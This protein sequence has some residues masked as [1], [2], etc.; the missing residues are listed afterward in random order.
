M[1]RF[2]NES[3]AIAKTGIATNLNASATR[4]GLAT[5]LRN[6]Q[7][8]AVASITVVGPAVELQARKARLSKSL[9]KFAEIWSHRSVAAREA[10]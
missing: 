10:I 6:R 5:V 4:L 2:I 7:G 9:L 1:D 3:P 8:E